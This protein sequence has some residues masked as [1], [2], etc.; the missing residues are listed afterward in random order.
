MGK[1]E[2]FGFRRQCFSEMFSVTAEKTFH[3]C[4]N[5][6]CVETAVCL[7]PWHI[8]EGFSWEIGSAAGGTAL[9]QQSSR[10]PLFGKWESHSQHLLRHLQND[11]AHLH[12]L[13]FEG[14][15]AGR[16]QLQGM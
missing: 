4:I 16:S 13:S 7:H 15:L 6:W 14:F 8:R 5:K 2:I 3:E 9:A 11:C 1:K 10:L 12:K